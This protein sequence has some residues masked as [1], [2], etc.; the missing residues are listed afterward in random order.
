MNAQEQQLIDELVDRVR[1]TPVQNKDTEA[2][3]RLQQGLANSPDALYILA[4][5]VI[6]QKYGLEQAQT[7][8]QAMQNELDTLHQ[9]VAQAQAHPSGGSFLSHIFG[10][11]QPSQSQ[12]TPSAPT[13]QGGWQSVNSGPYPPTA[14]PAPAAYPASG[15]GYGQPG[16][17]GGGGFGSGGGFLQGALQTAAGVAMGEMAVES[18]E[19]LFHG[20]GGGG[21][22]SRGFEDGGRPSETIINNYNDGDEPRHGSEGSR[23]RGDSSFYNPSDDASRNNDQGSSFAE[24]DI[25]R[26]EDNGNDDSSNDDSNYDSGDDSSSF[27]PGD[28]GG[29]GGDDGNY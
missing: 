16:G 24:T 7:R 17:F 5:T 22:G 11:S 14:V 28:D 26:D 12:P 21:Y 9:Q 3:L 6:V 20:F 23:D 2:E 13:P 15:Y 27:D 8:M 19:S 25:D 10:G 18:M 1:N 4:Q 29:S